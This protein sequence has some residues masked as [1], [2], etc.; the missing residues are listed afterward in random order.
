VGFGGAKGKSWGEYD[1]NILNGI[2]NKIL[3]M[4]CQI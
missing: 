2:I 3:K 4:M 1:Q